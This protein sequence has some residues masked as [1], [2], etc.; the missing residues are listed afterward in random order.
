MPDTI[1]DGSGKGYL[2]AVSQA[3]RLMVDSASKNVEFILSKEYGNMYN[4]STTCEI[5]AGINSILFIKNSNPNKDF[6]ISDIKFQ[7]VGSEETLPNVNNYLSLFLNPTYVSGGDTI[8]AI[9]LRQGSGNLSG[10][11]GYSCCEVTD[12]NKEAFRIYPNNSDLVTLDKK[13]SV[14][15]DFNNTLAFILN[16]AGT[17][18]IISVNILFGMTNKPS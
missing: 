7:I 11:Q 13:N 5:S 16:S 12:L 10:I 4:I 15:L 17:T 1:R 9:N 2:A 8:S 6:M 14:L 18:G 3:N